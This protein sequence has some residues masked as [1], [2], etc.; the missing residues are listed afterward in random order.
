[1]KHTCLK[2]IVL[3]PLLLGRP[4]SIR[5]EARQSSTPLPKPRNERQ[6]ED[7]I[8]KLFAQVRNDAKLHRLSRIVERISL[9]Q[10]VCTVA[11]TN[12]IPRFRSGFPV[13][14]NDSIDGGTNEKHAGN[15]TAK[16]DRES[17][18]YK[19]TNPGEITSELNR[20]ALFE[21]PRGRY[22]HSPGYAR[23]SVA[24]WP[25]QQATS[26]KA[27]YWVGV[28]LFWGAGNEF[29]LNH[30]SDAMEWKNEWKAFVAPECRD[31]Q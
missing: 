20:V 6:Q 11:V 4:F 7:A 23:Y 15:S 14:G 10:L 27:E 21:R 9:Q 25:V 29:F 24:V 30:F 1:M 31:L 19:T 13:L 22:G 5:L 17:A 18:L 16:M 8:A 28:E 26:E 12:K 3:L 2:L